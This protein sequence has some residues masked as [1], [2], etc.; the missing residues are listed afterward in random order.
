MHVTII[1]I[2]SLTNKPTNISNREN[3]LWLHIL[4]N[5]NLSHMTS[6]VFQH[7][8]VAKVFNEDLKVFGVRFDVSDHLIE[9]LWWARKQVP[10]DATDNDVIVQAGIV[11]PF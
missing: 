7:I 10:L 9:G 4:N 5:I 8:Q 6:Q 1:K 2:T 3:T 11:V